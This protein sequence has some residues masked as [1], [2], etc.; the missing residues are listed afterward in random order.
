MWGPTGLRMP[1]RCAIRRTVS[2]GRF[3]QVVAADG[4]AAVGDA[5]RGSLPRA[6][7]IGRASVVGEDAPCDPAYVVL[8]RAVEPVFQ[9][10]FHG[11]ILFT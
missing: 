7:F 9:L 4:A 5:R 3:V 6:H 2:C 1:A 11:P 10:W 8:L